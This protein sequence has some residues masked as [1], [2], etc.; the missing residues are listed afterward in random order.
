[1]YYIYV[2]INLFVHLP[3][4]LTDPKDNAGEATNQQQK[5]SALTSPSTC[6]S[7]RKKRTILLEKK[8]SNRATKWKKE[9]QYEKKKHGTLQKQF[10]VIMQIFISVH[11]IYLMRA[12]AKKKNSS[13]CCAP[14]FYLPFPSIS[15]IIASFITDFHH[16]HSIVSKKINDERKSL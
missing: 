9:K 15:Q 11:S 16:I 10:A 2:I 5:K 14:H 7:K 8:G 13:L 12:M 6:N 3:T 1:M 4:A